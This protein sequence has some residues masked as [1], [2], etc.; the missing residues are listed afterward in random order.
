MHKP[1]KKRE[2]CA[3]LEYVFVKYC[4]GWL[5]PMNNQKELVRVMALCISGDK[6][7]SESVMAQFNDDYMRHQHDQTLMHE[8]I[9]LPYP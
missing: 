6:P 3:F 4:T 5:S 2:P 1:Q 8:D 9:N 7:L